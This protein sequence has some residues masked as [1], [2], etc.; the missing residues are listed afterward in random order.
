MN[1]PK[2]GKRIPAT[3][4]LCKHC[5]KRISRPK[6]GAKPKAPP[7]AQL[8]QRQLLIAAAVGILIIALL[9][10]VLPKG[11]KRKQALRPERFGEEIS[12]ERGKAGGE[13]A[14]NAVYGEV[15]ASHIRAT[16][17]GTI[18]VK[19]LHTGTVYTFSVGWHTSYHPR[20]YPAIGERVKVYHLHDKG[21]RKAT[22]VIIDQ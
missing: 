3:A 4:R 10:A 17:A 2:C 9:L 14:S 7:R 21:L 5:G 11:G 16:R 18:T 22:Q 20:R 15:I 19:S 1:C 13:I 6:K 8:S 12:I